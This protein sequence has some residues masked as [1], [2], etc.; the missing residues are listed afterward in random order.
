MVITSIAIGRYGSDPL[1]PS[2]SHV[3][4]NTVFIYEGVC[5]FTH[6]FRGAW[7]FSHAH[8]RK[9]WYSLTLTT[10]KCNRIAKEKESENFEFS[11]GLVQHLGSDRLTDLFNFF[12]N[13][14]FGQRLIIW[15]RLARRMFT[16]NIGPF[17]LMLGGNRQIK[18]IVAKLAI[19]LIR[20]TVPTFN[21]SGYTRKYA[22]LNYYNCTF[23]EMIR[24]ICFLCQPSW[25]NTLK[26]IIAV[27]ATVKYP[28]W[29]IFDIIFNS[30]S[31]KKCE[32]FSFPKFFIFRI[33]TGISVTQTHSTSLLHTSIL[34]QLV[35]I[36]S[37]LHQLCTIRGRQCRQCI[38][39]SAN[40][41]GIRVH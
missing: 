24:L 29:A 25:N 2:V 36:A 31:L 16:F 35:Q 20:C 30:R 21:R 32:I 27:T 13:G 26:I 8:S 4:Q 5:E 14:P 34:N 23:S 18:W 3:S 12:T 37:N 40:T 15:I 22:K 7:I 39:V 9:T 41:L 33:L 1:H 10:K 28:A 38:C 11:N 19:I 17:L 6:S